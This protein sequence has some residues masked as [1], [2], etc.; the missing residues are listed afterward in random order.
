MRPGFHIVA[1]GH[2]DLGQLAA[3]LGVPVIAVQANKGQGL[4]ELKAALS[5]A[6]AVEIAPRPSPFSAAFCQEV[7]DL[8]A[9]LTAEAPQN[10]AVPRY[11]A[12]RLLLDTGG[13][14]EAAYGPRHE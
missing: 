11:L 12:E 1:L 5:A 10:G 13:Y 3:R 9:A 4:S 7:S 14:L 8:Q 2:I 6:T